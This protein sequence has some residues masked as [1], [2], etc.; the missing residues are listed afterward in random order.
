MVTRIIAPYMKVAEFLSVLL[1]QYSWRHIYL[2]FHNNLGPD[3]RKG[4]PIC[5]D[6]VEAVD[7]VIGPTVKIIS[8]TTVD[9]TA[10]N[11]MTLDKQDDNGYVLQRDNFNENY[12]DI[13][14]FDLY[15]DNIRKASRGKYP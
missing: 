13:K 5:Y 3:A 2:L 14:D 10:G 8:K 7:K 4:H 11:G 12:Y 9:D 1:A 15:F 6:I